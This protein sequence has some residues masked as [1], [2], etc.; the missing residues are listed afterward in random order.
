MDFKPI[1]VFIR[2]NSDGVERHFDDLTWHGDFI[3]SEG[4]FACDCNRGDFFAFAAG[5]DADRE[6]GHG[7]FSV[8]IETL[9]GVELYR[10]A[11]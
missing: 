3:W 2:R 10:D 4:N 11:P 6:C 5:E 7:D 9:D 1:R 8:R